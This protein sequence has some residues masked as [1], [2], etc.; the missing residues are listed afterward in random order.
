MTL[1]LDK[2]RM[3]I[4]GQ[5]AR[6]SS[7]EV[8]QSINPATEEIIGAVPNGTHEDLDR[9]IRAARVAF[10]RS[11]WSEDREFRIRCIRQ[12][13]SGLDKY[14]DTLRDLT[15]Q[16]VGS[17]ISMTR[18]AQLDDPIE[19]LE[20]VAKL[21]EGYGWERDLG[22]ARPLG[23]SSRRVVI[24]E[25]V[26]VIG[27]ITPWNVPHQVNLA[28]VGPALAAG[29]TVV[30]KSAPE[31]PLC[32]SALAQIANEETEIPAGVLNIVT[33]ARPE[34]GAQL[35]G[36]PRV[37]MVSFTGSTLTGQK[38]MANAAGT[39]KKIFLELGGKSACV[40]LDDA[41]IE[42]ATMVA[43]F[44]VCTHAGQGCAITTRL[45]APRSIFDEVVEATRQYMARLPAQDPTLE[46]TI[47]GPV[48]SDRQRRRIEGYL[49]LARKDGAI[50]VLGGDRPAR[51]ETGFFVEPTLLVGI[52]PRSRVVQE[53][54]FGPVLVA[55][56]HDGDQDAID[57]ANSTPYGLSASV[58]SSDLD[59]AMTVARGIRSGTVSVNGG[60]W[61]SPDVPFGGYKASGLGR[62][63]GIEGFEEYLETKAIASPG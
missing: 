56:A 60:L 23:I 22:V 49:D 24:K 34:L 27:A 33:S 52:D 63:G 12:L 26:G 38:V 61:Y 20:W 28:K 58:W 11:R 54:I 19:S 5:L 30:L 40:I 62:E 45:I 59:R 7:H 57:L 41:D 25:P 16:D 13:K 46:S 31:T 55:Y 2:N 50:F 8:F 35:V 9:A 17:P 32:A 1:A 48:I 51:P 6:S 10:D 39:L 43:A 15:V 37:D 3:L 18:H 47:C 14:R 21:A 4:N 53:E 42:M 36:D 44:T 29:N